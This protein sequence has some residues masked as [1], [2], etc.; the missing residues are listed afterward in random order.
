MRVAQQDYKTFTGGIGE[1]GKMNITMNGFAFS[2]LINNLYAQK[3]DS[4][5]RELAT[6]G[7]DG[8]AAVGKLD[9]PLEIQLPSHFDPLF[10]VR[11][12]GCSMPH[13]FMMAAEGGYRSLFS[14]T[15]R[16]T[17]EQVGML[18]LGRVSPLAYTDAYT[19]TCWS[20]GERRD[21]SVF[22]GADGVP[23]VA[24][25]ATV[26][27][28]DPTGVK[29]S[30]PVKA[31][32][33]RAFKLA[34]DRVLFAFDPKPTII[35]ESYQHPEVSIYASGSN[36]TVYEDLPFST[37]IYAK[38]GCVLYPISSNFIRDHLKLNTSYLRMV[39]DFPIGQLS[40]ATSRE[41]LS[42]DNQ[43]VINLKVGFEKALEEMASTVVAQIDAE[44]DYFSAC[45]K[46]DSMR[47]NYNSGTQAIRTLI[48]NRVKWKGKTLKQ[49]FALNIDS[50]ATPGMYF[51]QGDDRPGTCVPY[52]TFRSKIHDMNLVHSS[53]AQVRLYVEFPDLKFGTARM[54]HVMETLVNR[55]DRVLWLRPVNKAALTS[56]LEE[57]GDIPWVDLATVQPP[58]RQPALPG[59]KKN[60]RI[61][62]R[63][64]E[65]GQIRGSAYGAQYEDITPT[66][67]M[68][69]MHQVDGSFVC[70][71]GG[72]SQ[73]IYGLETA[74]NTLVRGGILLPDTRV[75]C[76]NKTNAPR[77]EKVVKTPRLLHEYVQE[78]VKA[79]FDTDNLRIPM[80]SYESKRC[81]SVAEYLRDSQVP[82][83]G[84]LKKFSTTY[85]GA[86]TPTTVPVNDSGME[87]LRVWA[88]QCLVASKDSDHVDAR[89]TL[90]RQ[91]PL[92]ELIMDRCYTNKLDQI[93]HYLT[94]LLNAKGA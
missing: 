83:W 33:V 30:Y 61:K 80:A 44:P 67:D 43:T 66:K 73:E 63:Y 58:K 13:E 91:Y 36:W 16:D 53:M 93:T 45:A 46:W 4:P 11:D 21:Y 60:A 39:V 72:R 34:A 37:G 76:I 54:K 8:H 7:R 40:V 88:P 70:Q 89:D 15:K 81:Y 2:S 19:V 87:V 10:A 50:A 5:F 57:H 31:S 32:D 55:G 47:G 49:K 74:L 94:L 65:A 29:V 52:L 84:D 90:Y 38:Q 77:L 59:M 12:F 78:L 23:D 62:M 27:S 18:G 14:S 75:Y 51:D 41:E 56:W 6:N 9:V 22:L 20:N 86:T 64:F 71:P 92:L 17:D 42:Y 68:I 26:P 35:N 82:L 1:T 85:G 25:L 24:H 28:T 48:E 3:I 79:K 69:F